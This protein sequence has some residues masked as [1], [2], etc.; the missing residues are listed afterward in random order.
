MIKE[1]VPTVAMDAPVTAKH[2]GFTGGVGYFCAFDK[3]TIDSL[4]SPT[5]IV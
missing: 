3:A 4:R 5:D 1:A 2:G